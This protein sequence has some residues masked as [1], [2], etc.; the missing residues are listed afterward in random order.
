MGGSGGEEQFQRR[1][2][3]S[4]MKSLVVYSSKSGNTK[5]V[6]EAVA[7]G[8]GEDTVLATPADAPDY[9]DFDFV[10]VGFWIEKERPNFEVQK[11]L[12]RLKGKKVGVFFTLGAD[13]ASDH[14]QIC[15]ENVKPFFEENEVLGYFMCQGKI[16]PARVKWV[17][18]MP[19]SEMLSTEHPAHWDRAALHPDV[20]DLARAA[21]TFRSMAASLD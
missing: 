1:K 16:D 5:R 21:E 10:A 9:R 7:R 4:V 12:R 3:S 20:D 13:S 14:A 11:Y 17:R 8:L 2:G 19:P 6:A 18:Q 15:L